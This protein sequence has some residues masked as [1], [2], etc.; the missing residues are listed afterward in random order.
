MR[1]WLARWLAP[2]LT[3]HI[4]DAADAECRAA[5]RL[6]QQV[7]LAERTVQNAQQQVLLVERAVQN[8]QHQR[9][10]NRQELVMLMARFDALCRALQ[11][12]IVAP[13]DGTDAQGTIAPDGPG[14]AA[15][16]L[17]TAQA[18]LAA[19]RG[20]RALAETAIR[21]MHE[22]EEQ[23]LSWHKRNTAKG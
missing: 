7:L 3:R 20:C 6:E 22:T 4:M 15:K 16:V 17:A 11:V 18:E 23:M 8:A 10:R 13:P 1:A 12:E 19:I 2:A 9:D 21:R 14:A 5:S